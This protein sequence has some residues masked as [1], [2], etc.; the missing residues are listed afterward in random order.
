MHLTECFLV[1]I[2]VI[3][4][5]RVQFFTSALN[6]SLSTKTK[7]KSRIA[8]DEPDRK[9]KTGLRLV[10]VLCF[11]ICEKRKTIT[12]EYY[13]SLIDKLKLD[14]L[15]KWLYLKKNKVLLHQDKISFHT[16][17]AKTDELQ[18]EVI[19]R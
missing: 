9:K 18:F 10:M 5:K 19:N 8:K 14:I 1:P 13:T 4:V 7:S 15:R 3:A 16:S 2:R 17:L 12:G 6:L 11:V